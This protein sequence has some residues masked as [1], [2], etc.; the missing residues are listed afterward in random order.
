[1][2][3]YLVRVGQNLLTGGLI[4]GRGRFGNRDT[5]VTQEDGHVKTETEIGTMLP[6]PKEY[7]GLPATT[8]S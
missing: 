8:R 4:K 5:G 1:M 7:Q 6:Q 3:S 2:R